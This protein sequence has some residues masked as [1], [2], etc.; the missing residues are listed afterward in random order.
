MVSSLKRPSA[1]LS[2]Q[3]A[4]SPKK[5]AQQLARCSLKRNGFSNFLGKLYEGSLKRWD[6]RSSDNSSGQSKT[7]RISD[8]V[9]LQKPPILIPPFTQNV[10]QRM[11]TGPNYI[12]ASKEHK[13]NINNSNPALFITIIYD[14]SNFTNDPNLSELINST[15]LNYQHHF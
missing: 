5:Y 12:K 4:V 7:C 10:F 3:N 15:T 8:P 11:F 14:L 2:D 13:I 9:S 6:A 1:R